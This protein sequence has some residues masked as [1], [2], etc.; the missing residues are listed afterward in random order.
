MDVRWKDIGLLRGL[1]EEALAKV[2]PIFEPRQMGAGARVI[3]ENEPGEEMFVLVEGRVRIVKSMLLPVDA[4]A[5][6]GVDPAKVLAT[7]TGEALP[8]FG[9]MGLISDHPRS[10]TVETLEPSTFLVTDRARFFDL[11][12]REPELGCRLL[13][14]LAVRMADLVRSGNQQVMKLTTA[15][16]LVLSGKK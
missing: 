15:L 12:R 1:D 11:L 5:L 6:G 8:F 9:E 7:L 13:T 3:V 2:R 10:A 14:A 16:A 4:S